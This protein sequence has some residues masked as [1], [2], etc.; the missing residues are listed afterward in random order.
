MISIKKIGLTVII[1]IILV[2]GFY[3][4]T[5]TISN[6]TGKSIFGL[7]VK[8]PDTEN[9]DAFAS[10]LTEKKV[11]MYGTDWCHY[12]QNQKELFG[13]SFKFINYINCDK[14]KQECITVGVEGYPTWEINNKLY[15]GVQQ[16][17]KLAELTGCSI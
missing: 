10:C 9:L 15:P 2:I 8:N 13:D 17:T 11:K 14:K 3:Y 7:F 4:V 12:C 1:L 16:L 5:K 6:I